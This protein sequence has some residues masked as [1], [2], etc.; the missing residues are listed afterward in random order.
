MRDHDVLSYLSKIM[1]LCNQSNISCNSAGHWDKIGE[2]TEASLKVL[3]E[4]LADPSMLGSSGSHTPGNDMWTKMFKREATL[5][6]ARD[7]KSM[8]VI[9]APQGG[10]SKKVGSIPPS[11][12]LL[13]SFLLSFFQYF[14]SQNF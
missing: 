1:S 8:S 11:P 4:K 13:L 3:V 7:R 9:V 10:S 12:H 5:E 2:S 6:F 14:L